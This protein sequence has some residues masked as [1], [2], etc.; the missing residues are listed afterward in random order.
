MEKEELRSLQQKASQLRVEGKYK[1]AIECSNELLEQGLAWE[2]H[3][4]VLTAYIILA[5][6]YYCLGDISEAFHVIDL[7]LE[8]V[9][10]HGDRNDHLNGFNILFLLYEHNKE[11]GKAKDTLEKV[12]SLGIELGHYNI[13]SNAYSN[14]SSVYASEGD[15]ASALE[16]ALHGWEAAKKHEPVTPILEYRVKLN[17]VNAHIGLNQLDEAGRMVE[18]MVNSPLLDSFPREKAQ[19]FDLYGRYW[20][21]K[22]EY[23][24]ALHALNKSKEVAEEISDTKL[25]KNIQ[26]KRMELCKLTG[27]MELGYKV[28]QEYIELLQDIREHEIALTV[29]RMEVKHS[30]AEMEKKVHLD[31]LTGL[32]NRRYM[33]VTANEWLQNAVQTKESIVCIALDLDNLKTMNDTYGH[34]FGDNVIKEMGRACRQQLR[35]SDLMA[36]FGGDEFVI[37]L[38]HML[39]EDGHRKAQQL[40]KA[41]QELNI[42]ADGVSIPITCSIGIADNQHGHISTF[43]ELFHL[44]DQAL[45]QAKQEGKNRICLV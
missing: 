4:S 31:Y 36:R 45:Y 24:E 29:A 26:N 35:N 25:L 33:E 3:K 5:A 6:S 14:Y 2:D 15:Y 30:L 11:Y 34:L 28:Q 38:R 12:I 44:A 43:D 7:Y 22:E 32:Y 40:I 16:Q 9:A 20:M 10:D 21:A 18:E 13:V 42:K 19:T 41:I 39:V 23:L 27:D 17:V 8:Y 1:E 37:F